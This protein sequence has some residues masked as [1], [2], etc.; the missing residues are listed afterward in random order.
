MKIVILYRGVLM[1]QANGEMIRVLMARRDWTQQRLSRESGLSEVT[2]RRLLN[3]EAFVSSTIDR[4][5]DT[6]GCRAIDLVKQGPDKQTPIEKE[7]TAA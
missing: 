7:T 2:I 3:G 4:L 5:A 1:I 6:F